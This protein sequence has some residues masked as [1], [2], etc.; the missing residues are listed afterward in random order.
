MSA[1]LRKF[2]VAVVLGALGAHA[3]VADA[4]AR[5]PFRGRAEGAATSMTPGPAGVTLTTSARGN[6]THIGLFRR[7]EEIL[8]DPAT[9]QIS[10]EVVFTAANGD[11]LNGTVAGGFVEPGVARGTYALEGGS[12]RFATAIG[13]AEFVLTTPDGLN[14]TVEFEGD[15]E[16]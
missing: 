12:G 8:L 14:F 6:A 13:I 5:P 11:R 2:A 1:T 4:Q 9:G 3:F 7:H 16:R 10:G 15:L